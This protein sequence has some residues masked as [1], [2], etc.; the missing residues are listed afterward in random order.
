MVG[1]SKL[2][3]IN[4]TRLVLQKVDMRREGVKSFNLIQEFGNEK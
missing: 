2:K 1:D 4:N 3:Y